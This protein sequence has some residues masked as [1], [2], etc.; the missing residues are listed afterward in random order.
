MRMIRITAFAALLLGVVLWLVS[1][2]TPTWVVA[3]GMVLSHAAVLFWTRDTK[4]STATKTSDTADVQNL[5]E[6][7]EMTLTELSSAVEAINEVSQAQ[8]LGAS[9]Q[10]NVIHQ[11]SHSLNDFLDLSDRVSEKVQ[12]ITQISDQTTIASN[13]GQTAIQTSITGMEQIRQQVAVIAETIATLARLTRRIDT[14]IT[15]V[16]EIATQSNLLAL[17]ASIEAARAGTHGRGFAVVADEVRTLAGQSTQAANEIRTLLREVQGA[18]TETI[19]ATQTG[20]EEVNSGVQMTRLADDAMRQIAD[21]INT[22]NEAT[23]DIYQVIQQQVNGL[24]E[25]SMNIER[26]NH[27]ARQTVSGM[28]VIQTV[29]ANLNRLSATLKQT[30]TQTSP[31][32]D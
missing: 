4:P 6:Q 18:I 27:I 5:T 17:N 20:M 24:E 19:D 2:I 23:R 16:S 25:I 11:I 28:Q 21:E 9:E 3:G 15:S 13:S 31:T 22:S 29:S 8:S 14:I 32:A 12:A 26:V 7:I 10:A 30:L 1:N